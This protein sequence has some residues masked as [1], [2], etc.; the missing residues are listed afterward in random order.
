VK[1]LTVVCAA[2]T[3]VSI[4]GTAVSRSGTQPAWY[5]ISIDDYFFH[6]KRVEREAARNQKVPDSSVNFEIG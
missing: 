4:F 2:E 1:R 3:A 6:V 5:R